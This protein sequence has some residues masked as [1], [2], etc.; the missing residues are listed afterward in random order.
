MG[1]E[2]TATAKGNPTGGSLTTTKATI[3]ESKASPPAAL[4][5]AVING[6]TPEALPPDATDTA[7]AMLSSVD[8]AKGANHADD[9]PTA[10]MD[11]VKGSP[12]GVLLATSK[13]TGSMATMGAADGSAPDASVPAAMDIADPKGSTADGSAPD[14]LVPAAMDIADP[15][16]STADGSSPDAMVPDA[17]DIAD[18][19]GSTADGFQPTA[20]DT[21]SHSSVDAKG[22]D[23]DDVLASAA[24]GA[25]AVDTL[26]ADVDAANVDKLLNADVDAAKGFNTDDPLAARPPKFDIKEVKSLTAKKDWQGI[27]ELL[28]KFLGDCLGKDPQDAGI[29]HPGLLLIPRQEKLIQLMQ[30]QAFEEA[31]IFCEKFIEPLKKCE[32]KF[33]PLSLEW[34]I[35][36]LI[37][38][39]R[40]RSVPGGSTVDIASS[41]SDYMFL[42][43]PR[44]MCDEPNHAEEGTWQFAMKLPVQTNQISSTGKAVKPRHGFRCL[45]CGWTMDGTISI[46]GLKKH[47]VHSRDGKCCLNVTQDLLDRMKLIGGSKGVPDLSTIAALFKDKKRKGTSSGSAANQNTGS[48]RSAACESPSSV[49]GTS[50]KKLKVAS[51]TA[52]CN[53]P[54]SPPAA[55]AVLAADASSRGLAKIVTEEVV[56]LRRIAKSL[57]DLAESEDPEDPDVSAAI[58]LEQVAYK[59]MMAAANRRSGTSLPAQNNALALSAPSSE[60]LSKTDKV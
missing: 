4:L 44:A 11:A 10:T 60:T 23:H 55:A 3:A 26:N 58:E 18:P 5:P 1:E 30:N 49:V 15:K 16:G 54:S 31:K 25:N 53:L 51:P 50:K 29:I 52:S 2:P 37:M 48:S 28:C 32:S 33:R 19:K 21:G 8:A 27:D 41:V 6:S 42:Y 20:M 35:D 45:A 34:R 36:E 22:T 17:M 56:T 13:G 24:K 59:L 47:I 38:I 57:L 7:K 9:E 43:F 12:T 40:Q 39:M 46:T 14:A